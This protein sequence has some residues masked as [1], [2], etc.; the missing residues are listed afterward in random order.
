MRIIYQDEYEIELYQSNNGQ[1]AVIG[2]IVVI[3]DEE[4]RVKSRILYPEEN[5]MVV[6]LS[7]SVPRAMQTESN[8]NSRLNQIN[9][10]ILQTNKRID[11][12]DKKNRALSEQIVTVRKHINQRIRQDKQDKKDSQ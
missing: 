4:Y 1:A 9:S 5:T 12:T 3:E 11:A 7:Q 10:A 8:E 6:V 2:D